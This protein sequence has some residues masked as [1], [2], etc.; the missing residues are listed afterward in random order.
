MSEVT[1]TYSKDLLP[2]IQIKHN[3][4]YIN[5]SYAKQVAPEFLKAILYSEGYDSVPESL[6]EDIKTYPL[7]IDQDKD[8][9]VV[10]RYTSY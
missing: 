8:V 10:F 1:I 7:P 3:G 5:K 4:L 6:I 9:T 2:F